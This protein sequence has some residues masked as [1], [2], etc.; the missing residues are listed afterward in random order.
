MSDR[1]IGKGLI[2]RLFA[3]SLG[4]FEES[5]CGSEMVSRR[6]IL[7]R[8][9]DDLT[10]AFAPEMEDEEDVWFQKDKLY[11]ESRDRVAAMGAITESFV[12]KMRRLVSDLGFVMSIARL[13]RVFLVVRR[14]SEICDFSFDVHAIRKTVSINGQKRQSDGGPV[15]GSVAL[16]HDAI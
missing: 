1:F 7:L 15:V 11:K 6:R 5:S 3:S 9:R 13:R 2:I 8:S 12:R 4:P 10:Q 14:L 16:E